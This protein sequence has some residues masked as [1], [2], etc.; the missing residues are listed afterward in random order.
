MRFLLEAGAD[1]SLKDTEGL[2]V[3]D[4]AAK[5]GPTGLD[6]LL[7]VKAPSGEQTRCDL[8]VAR[9]PEVRGLRLGMPLR[10]A[11]SRFNPPRVAEA[12]WCGRQTLESDWRDDLLGQAAP[13]LQRHSL[14]CD[15]GSGVRCVACA[16][17]P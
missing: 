15:Y 11:A 6:R 7:L 17:T 2:D 1:T 16:P 4:H 3:L 8:G 9:S 13:R 14:E 10:E 12:E 5:A